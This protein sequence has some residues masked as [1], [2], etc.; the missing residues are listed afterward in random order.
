MKKVTL[1][2]LMAI[3]FMA[4][5]PANAPKKIKLEFEP[6]ALIGHFSRLN[7]VKKLVDGSNMPHDQVKYIVATIDSLQ[8]EISRQAGDTS[9][10]PVPKK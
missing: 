4:F 2:L 8:T 9:L 7:D 1:A 10:N 6:N 5:T 3:G